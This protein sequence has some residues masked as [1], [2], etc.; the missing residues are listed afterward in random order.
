MGGPADIPEG[1]PTLLNLDSPTYLNRH[2]WTC[3]PT[4]M[5][6]YKKPLCMVPI[7]IKLDE[8][9][10]HDHSTSAQLL[11]Q[12]FHD[13]WAT[14]EGHLFI[15]STEWG[16][17]KSWNTANPDY[18]VNVGDRIVQVN[19]VKGTG[20]QLKNEMYKLYS[21]EVSGAGLRECDGVYTFSEKHDAFYR[22][23]P[24]V[25]KRVEKRVEYYKILCNRERFELRDKHD[26]LLYLTKHKD[27]HQDWLLRNGDGPAPHV[28]R[29]IHTL[30]VRLVGER[31][32]KRSKSLSKKERKGGTKERVCA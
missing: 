15:A 20:Q 7:L 25:E 16:P 29:R 28:Q 10:L 27:L 12:M 26:R 13:A 8:L 18:M 23:V 3:S 9:L 24:T 32:V 21:I 31:M 1:R 30:N 6:E 11:G 19:S 17:I 22:E 2:V 4:P 14:R 5:K